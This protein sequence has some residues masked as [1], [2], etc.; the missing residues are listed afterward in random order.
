MDFMIIPTLDV[1]TIFR[2]VE[3][4]RDTI[5]VIK[6]HSGR[7]SLLSDESVENI[8]ENLFRFQSKSLRKLAQQSGLSYGSLSYAKNVLVFHPY[9]NSENTTKDKTFGD[10]CRFKT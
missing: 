7:T 9:M 8:R 3:H 1:S 4:F 5:T 2:V 10:Y 6:K